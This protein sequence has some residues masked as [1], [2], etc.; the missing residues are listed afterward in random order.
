MDP[1][2]FV[3]RGSLSRP[4]RGSV[5][6]WTRCLTDWKWCMAR[7]L[8]VEDLLDRLRWPVRGP[9]NE[10]LSVTTWCGG[11][12]L[13][14]L[15]FARW[16]REIK[17]GISTDPDIFIRLFQT[18]VYPGLDFG[19]MFSSSWTRNWGW[20]WSP[21][22]RIDR[23]RPEMNENDLER[24]KTGLYFPSDLSLVAKIEL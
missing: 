2:V 7:S 17:G 22:G 12:S 1:V 11:L 4:V 6:R 19:P 5:V 8:P 13:V 18:A 15:A 9:L 23:N 10:G 14:K 24:P 21:A 16:I 3:V 20:H